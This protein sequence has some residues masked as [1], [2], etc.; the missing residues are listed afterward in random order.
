[1]T[2]MTTRTWMK[3]P[4]V[5]AVIKPSSQS[6]MSTTAIVQSM[7]HPPLRLERRWSMERQKIARPVLAWMRSYERH[8]SQI[9]ARGGGTRAPGTVTQPSLQRPVGTTA[10]PPWPTS[11]TFAYVEAHLPCHGAARR[12]MLNLLGWRPVEDPCWG[13][14]CNS[15][16]PIA[17]IL[18]RRRAPRAGGADAV[19]GRSRRCPG[20]SG[21]R[22][23][24]PCDRFARVGILQEGWRGRPGSWSH[25]SMAHCPSQSA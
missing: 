25:P 23:G 11:R 16:Q 6:T 7:C 1:M 19:G 24:E 9:S 12:K 3:P 8:G 5:C 18:P 2:A 15:C 4:I 14:A 21:S 10:I 13:S 22:N 20:H 17:T